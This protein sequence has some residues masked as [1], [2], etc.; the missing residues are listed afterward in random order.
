MGALKALLAL[1]MGTVP[2]DKKAEAERL[3]KEA[4]AEIAKQAQ[5]ADTPSTSTDNAALVRQ[6]EVLS[7]TVKGLQETL[8]AERAEREKVQKTIADQAKADT[9]KRIEAAIAK[10][11]EE[12]RIP[13]QNDD[14]KAN[15]TS[16][17]EAN[18]DSAEKALAATPSV[19]TTTT[20]TTTKGTKEEGTQQQAQ[21]QTPEQIQAAAREAFQ[22]S[23]N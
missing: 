19:K 8:A 2:D 1:V 5:P 22:A 12:G 11:I 18:Y 15:W 14:A 10:G 9:A 21:V 17:F 23:M 20:N 3:A 13:A 16:L 4:E 6:I 7:G